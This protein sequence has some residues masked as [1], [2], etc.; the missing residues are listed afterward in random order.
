MVLFAL[1]TSA[2]M[3]QQTSA[4]IPL[5]DCA[6]SAVEHFIKLRSLDPTSQQDVYLLV[7]SQ[8]DQ[9]AVQVDWFNQPSPDFISKTFLPT[10]K[11][12]F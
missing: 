12:N 3:N 6:K 9:H 2:S 10:L 1:D 4:G 8:Q 7:T 11:V 5:L